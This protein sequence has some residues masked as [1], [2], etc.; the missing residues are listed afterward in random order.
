MSGRIPR[1]YRKLQRALAWGG[2][3]IMAIC[4][5]W[6]QLL[7]RAPWTSEDEVAPPAQGGVAMV[8]IDAGHGGQDSG[9]MRDGILEKDLTL[10]LARRLDQLLRANGFRT[11]LTRA[12]DEYVSLS[13]RAVAANGQRNCVFVSIHFDEGSRAT[14]SGVNTYYAARQVPK[15]PLLPSWLPFLQPVSSEPANLESQS[16]AGIVQQAHLKNLV[17]FH[18]NR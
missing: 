16:L 5:V 6:M 4:F 1:G 7:P 10:D 17:Y 12:G 15:S 13:N 8:I 11:M 18:N 9:T 2:L 14:A 3:F